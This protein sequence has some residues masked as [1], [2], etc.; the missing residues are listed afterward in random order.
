MS[1]CSSAR[2]ASRRASRMKYSSRGKKIGVWGGTLEGMALLF[3]RG[4][5][6]WMTFQARFRTLAPATDKD[7][8]LSKSS[9]R[10]RRHA[11][12][13]GLALMMVWVL[14]GTGRAQA[15]AYVPH[16]VIVG[17][18]TGATVS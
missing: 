16:E 1:S 3:G 9:C 8:M 12:V 5:C 4:T 17:Y 15:A 6:R 18:R 11:V 13:I 10:S 14:A 2:E 7:R